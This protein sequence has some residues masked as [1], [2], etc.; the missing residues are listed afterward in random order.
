MPPEEH[1]EMTS[2]PLPPKVLA[3]CLIDVT[4]MSFCKH[5]HE[6]DFFLSFFFSY[7]GDRLHVRALKDES[8]K[9]LL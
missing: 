5:P 2:V 4:N 6:K 7:L 9:Y 3:I 1:V 8:T